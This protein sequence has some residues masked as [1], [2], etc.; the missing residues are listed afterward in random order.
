MMIMVKEDVGIIQTEYLIRRN[1]RRH[2]LETLYF[3]HCWFMGDL[4][5]FL[6]AVCSHIINWQLAALT[7]MRRLDYVVFTLKSTQLG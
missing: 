5:K 4:T 1:R 6:E 3:I 2:I 7:I